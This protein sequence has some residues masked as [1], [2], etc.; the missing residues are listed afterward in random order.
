MR[1][2][3]AAGVGI[4][5]LAVAA[6][7]GGMAVAGDNGERE[8]GPRVVAEPLTASESGPAL[9]AGGGP[10]IRTFYLPQAVDPPEDGGQ[11]AGAKCPKGEGS[12]I[13]GGAATSEGIVVSYLSQI[14][15]SNG[16]RADRV[17]W[18]GVDDNSA[19][20][21]DTASAIIEVHCAKGIKV[22]K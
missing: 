18:I 9:R 10:K 2:R 5:V 19:E 20:N 7:F 13:G 14:R 3:I 15:P 6:G 16:D 4:A 21:P 8:A 1:R 17:Y 22:Q 11:V 12:A